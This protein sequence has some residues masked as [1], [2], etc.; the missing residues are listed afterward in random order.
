MFE[1]ANEIIPEYRLAYNGTR[2][3]AGV[4]DLTS[5]DVDVGYSFEIFLNY[6]Q[7]GIVSIPDEVG[8]AFSHRNV[9]SHKISEINDGS[10]NNTIYNDIVLSSELHQI[11]LNNGINYSVDN[12]DEYALVGLY[13][14]LVIKG[15]EPG[16]KVLQTELKD[17]FKGGN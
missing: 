4:E 13:R 11:I 10:A 9:T 2:S 14:R 3:K 5:K 16:I 15:N 8:I 17:L 1:P 7:L 6:S 12:F